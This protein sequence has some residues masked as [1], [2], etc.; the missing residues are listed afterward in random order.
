MD[1]SAADAVR[2]D[3]H[4][5]PLAGLLQSGDGLGRLLAD[6][7]RRQRQI[8]FLAQHGPHHQQ[9]DGG[10]GEEL[11]AAGEETAGPTRGVQIGH[12]QG[13]DPPALRLRHEGPRFHHPPQH[14]GG[15]ERAAVGAGQDRIDRRLGQRPGHRLR[16]PSHVVVFEE[17]QPQ[18]E[19][20]ANAAED[21]LRG[22]FLGTEGGH[23]EHVTA[24]GCV[25]AVRLPVDDQPGHQLLGPLAVVQHDQGRLLRR[26]QGIEKLGE[27][28]DAAGFAE[29]FR[30]QQAQALPTQHAG[31]FGNSGDGGI[32]MLAQAA[33]HGGG[34]V[35]IGAGGDAQL[36]DDAVEHFEGMPAHLFGTLAAE[37]HHSLLR[38]AEGQL[39]QEPRLAAARFALH[40]HQ[41]SAAR[42]GPRDLFVQFFNF[43][44]AP[45]E[46][47]FGE[48]GAAVAGTD[49]ALRLE[50]PLAQ[51]RGDVRQVHQHRLGR[52]VAVARILAQQPLDGF[53]QGPRDFQAQASQLRGPHRHVLQEDPAHAVA[54]KGR[55]PGQALEEH[56]ARRIQI[57]R[58]GHFVVQGAGLFGRAI[59][60]GLRGA[61]IHGGVE[62]RDPHQIAVHQDRA[63][64]RHF[65]SDDDVGGANVAVQDAA[66]VHLVERRQQA[67]AHGQRVGQCQRSAAKAGLQA[68]A[69]HEV[70]NQVQAV[71]GPTQVQQGADTGA[72]QLP[73]QRSFV[74]QSHPRP[75][76]RSAPARA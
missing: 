76:R 46:G 18:V 20:R 72:G 64:Q 54:L 17:A 39:G 19:R 1:E 61:I 38:G 33:A 71:S 42:A 59:A 44:P 75:R 13:L 27:G 22:D 49:H 7:F 21:V 23:H 50:T 45:H 57:G 31:Q 40:Q 29:G 63:G 28:L 12:R 65:F 51:R 3:P 55:V 9:V 36:A 73:Q 43:P 34:Q 41:R 24:A 5:V 52:L 69:G 58:F 56:H 8:E 30:S 16:Q 70:A 35:G 4:V 10:L 47:R 25:A 26:A 48:R 15:H 60:R 2:A 66:A 37:D 62:L 11:D 68:C 6:E 74:L 67:A 53:V 14:G 32:A